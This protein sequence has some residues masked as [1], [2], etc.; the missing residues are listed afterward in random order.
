M[1]PFTLIDENGEDLLA[2]ADVAIFDRSSRIF[3]FV[4]WNLGPSREFFNI[5]PFRTS[6]ARNT[7]QRDHILRTLPPF[8]PAFGRN[9]ASQAPRLPRPDLL[10]TPCA[11]VRRPGSPRPGLGTRPGRSRLQPHR[12]D[13]HRS[14]EHTSELQSRQYL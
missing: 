12:P 7:N 11:L 3:N 13:V 4:H 6:L 14:E 9:R 8:A 10:G 5:V 1:H 2:R